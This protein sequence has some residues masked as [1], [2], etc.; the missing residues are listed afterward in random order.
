MS[1]NKLK[2]IPLGGCGEIGKNMILFQYG[3]EILI[4]D[5]G[6][7]F[8]NEEMFGVDF[9]IPDISYIL[10]QKNKVKGILLTHGHEDHIGALPFILKDLDVP[11]YGTPLTLGLVE[12][13]LEEFNIKEKLIRIKPGEKFSI[14]SFSIEAFRQTHSIPDSVGFAIETPVGLIVVSGDFKFDQSPIDGNTT[15]F[16]KLAEFGGR[17]VLALI[18]DTTNI[19]Q[20]GI[21]PSESTIKSTFE[22]IFST[23]KGRIFLVTFASNFHRIQQAINVAIKYHRKIAIAGKSLVSNIEVANKLGYL[24]IPDGI[25]VNIKDVNSLPKERVLILSTG[26]Q[27]EPYS[28]LV[29]LTNYS[30][31]QL[32]L[33]PDDTVVLATTP[34][35][36]NEIMVSRLVNQ[37]FRKGLEVIYGEKAGVH[38]SG[39]AA[40]EEIKMLINLLKP[41]Y[42]IPYHGEYRHLVLFKKLAQ[43]LGY[44]NENIKI[45]ENGN[46]LELDKSGMRII[47]KIDAGNVYVD[48]LGIGDVGNIVLK[49]RRRLSEDG[50]VV[51]GIL[52]DQATGLILEGPEI[53]SKGFVF[54]R[55]AEELF[56]DAKEKIRNLFQELSKNYNSTNKIDKKNLLR[57]AIEDFFYQEIR[58][59]PILIPILWEI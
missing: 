13:K 14:G 8:P 42:L 49:E 57:E 58:R 15:D 45:L 4:L 20:K 26:S 30:Y 56:E 55:E 29:L 23:A 48:G 34:I 46:V 21:T 24:N 22:N 52:I 5:A 43:S 27:G 31:K 2:I 17:G 41:K 9:V 25:L 11:I 19:E 54:E 7:M 18:C 37:L 44:S 38:V 28:A 3:D 59:R 35:P 10:S 32:A 36:G 16:R 33:N 47:D 12:K 51:I 40:Q 39:H 50:V 53:I 6:L 1:S